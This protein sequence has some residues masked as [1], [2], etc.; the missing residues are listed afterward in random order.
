V[1]VVDIAERVLGIVGLASD[2]EPENVDGY[3][4]VDGF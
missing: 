1:A 4:V 3:T 2:A